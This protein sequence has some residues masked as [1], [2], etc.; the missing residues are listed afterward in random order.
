MLSES[1]LI[2]LK[3]CTSGGSMASF[4]GVVS[5]LLLSPKLVH[6]MLTLQIGHRVSRCCCATHR[7]LQLESIIPLPDRSL[8][9]RPAQDHPAGRHPL[10]RSRRCS[11]NTSRHKYS[12]LQAQVVSKI[13]KQHY[14]LPLHM[15]LQLPVLPG[16][17]YVQRRVDSDAEEVGS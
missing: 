9:C 10:Q 14:P 1:R 5:I 16:R 17:R 15:V 2:F 13:F 12:D 6:T 3:S 8:Q 7:R 11:P 4:L